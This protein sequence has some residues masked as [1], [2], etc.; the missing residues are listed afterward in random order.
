ME[1]EKFSLLS[2]KLQLMAFGRSP[3]DLAA[4]VT[5]PTPLTVCACVRTCVCV[6]T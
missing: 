2:L 5:Y 1:G 4:V 3:L 6:K